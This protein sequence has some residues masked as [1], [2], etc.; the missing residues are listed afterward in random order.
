MIGPI[1]TKS[2]VT[3]CF[4]FLFAI[5]PLI[6]GCCNSQEKDEYPKLTDKATPEWS[7][8]QPYYVKPADGVDSLENFDGRIVEHHTSSRLLQI[9]RPAVGDPKKAPRIA[10]WLTKDGGI[11]W[12]RIGY[13]GLQQQYF[14][15]EVRTDDV[16][17]IRFMG[18]GIPPADC[19]PPRPH[20]NFHVDTTA[21]EVTVFISP[22]QDCYY[23]GQ[24]IRVEWQAHDLNLA[25]ELV[26]ISI[27]IDF[28]AKD[29]CWVPLVNSYP[30]FE[31]SFEFVIPEDAID[32]TVM[33]RIVAKDKANNAGLGYS[34][35]IDIV[36]ETVSMIPTAPAALQS[37]QAVENEQET[38]IL[39][40][41]PQA[42]PTLEE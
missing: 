24:T 36:Y 27:C 20:M 12:K 22:D 25:P 32:K 35:P 16:Y 11:N 40:T 34:C 19:K 6:G 18:P 15:Y 7:Y 30:S 33:I 13:F 26:E 31:G 42:F 29:L 39:T 14:P 37:T 4:S 1:L 21:P 3:F 38:Q 23:P 9:P 2:P 8:D 5:V 10:I 17:G 41:M 28:K